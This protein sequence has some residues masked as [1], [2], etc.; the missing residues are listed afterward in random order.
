MKKTIVTLFTLLISTF[1]YADGILFEG[2]EY[3][4]H[5]M[6]VP[7]GWTCPDESWLCGYQDKDHNRTAHTG[8]WYAFTNAEESWMFMPLYMSSDL[9]YR[10]HCW[11]ISDGSFELE[12]WAGDQA[13]PEHMTQLLF[14]V[15]VNS[16][17]YER[18]S[19]Y[20]ETI[21]TNHTHL[22]IRAVASPGAYHLTIDDIEVDMVNKYD[23]EVTPY[24]KDTVLSPGA[25][26]TFNY[27]VQN[28]GFEPLE[29]F[30]TP[31]TDAFHDITF[32]A[33]GQTGS[34]FPTV[35]D[36]V[37]KASCTAT[38]NSDIP[39]GS[40]VWIDIMLTVSCDCVT[41]MATLWV[42]VVEETSVDERQAP[43]L[44]YPNPVTDY[45][46]V[47][48]DGLRQVEI[49]DVWG[50]TRLTVP[51]DQDELRINLQQLPSGMYFTT[52]TTATG[53]VTE[54]IVK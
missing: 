21:L 23:M 7:I 19:N 42:D 38:L 5:D 50:R 49:T 40:R 33:N 16:G 3:A 26:V 11:A 44:V 17:Y 54:K 51:T 4:N 34:S 52:I 9:K 8:N 46:T 31:Y 27:K 30:M 2:F 24:E 15:T 20:V 37:V 32:T 12:F 43:V 53:K 22:G 41:R 1:I 48:A 36:E 45:V 14:S 25:V 47:Q 35:P 10:Y 18:F 39:I 6:T 29:I 28:T 13:S